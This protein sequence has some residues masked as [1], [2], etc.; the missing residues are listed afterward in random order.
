MNWLASL[1][2][3]DPKERVRLV[4]AFLAVYVIWGSTYLAIRVAIET[5]PP[6]VMAGTRFVIAGAVLYGWTALRR[7]PRPALPYWRSA[8]VVGALLLLGGNGLVTWAEQE[9]PSGLAA[10][11][12][13]S[14]PIWFVLLEALRPGGTRP[15]RRTLVGVAIGFAGIAL[16]IGPANLAS[17]L[18]IR[19]ISLLAVVLAPVSWAAGSLY[20]RRAALPRSPLQANG[21][22]MLAGGVLLLLLATATGQ[23]ADLD[24]GAVSASSAAAFFY[25]IVFGS[26]VAFTAY[27]WLLKATTPAKAST[28]AY[29]NPVVAVFLGWALADEPVTPGMLAAMG[30][31]L[32]AVALIGG[33]FS[34][35]SQRMRPTHKGFLS[36]THPFRSYSSPLLE[37]RPQADKGD[38]GIYA[39]APIAA[40]SLLLLFTGDIVDAE[41]LAQ[42][43]ASHRRFSIQ[44]EEGLYMVTLGAPEVSD[45]LNHSCAPTAGMSGQIG[46][47]ALRDLLPGEEIC[48]DYA[49]CDGSPYDEFDCS[50]GAPTCRGR[51]SGDDW[52]RPELQIRYA[53]YFSPY[54]QRRI[55]RKVA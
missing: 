13:A 16:L 6:F 47:V 37:L 43:P 51:V 19:P 29:V 7:T 35:I 48:V 9:V 50:C 40:G 39:T 55:D 27:V 24:L 3:D 45:Y 28:Y 44:V 21:M 42:V 2:G 54:L 14:T 26:I 12:I 4:A 15:A 36:M 31:I 46:V 52:R 8:I 34:G 25:L 22:E 33:M 32:F 1:L 17:G 30:I 53:G 20:S 23:W 10:L 41:Q 38:F 5:I 49:M 11:I 18:Q